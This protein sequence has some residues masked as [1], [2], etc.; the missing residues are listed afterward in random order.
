MKLTEFDVQ[1]AEALILSAKVVLCQLEVKPEVSLV[2]MKLAKQHNGIWVLWD[3]HLLCFY[4]V[5]MI[6]QQ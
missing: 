2:A 3:F 4:T 6:Y 1:Q 5:W